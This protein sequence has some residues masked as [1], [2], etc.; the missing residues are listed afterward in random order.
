MRQITEDKLGLKVVKR[1][2]KGRA[3]LFKCFI[4]IKLIRNMFGYGGE[5]VLSP[6]HVAQI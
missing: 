2:P 6:L 1:Y 4:A 3:K 5:G